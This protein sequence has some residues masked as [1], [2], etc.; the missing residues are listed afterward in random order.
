MADTAASTNKYTHAHAPAAG[1]QTCAPNSIDG[2]AARVVAGIVAAL[3]LASLWPP[4]WW[5]TIVLAIDF[6][7]RAWVGRTYSPLRWVAKRITGAL[8]V[9]VKPTYAP[10]KRFAARIGSA[11]TLLIVASHLL[12][13]G[14]LALAV[15]L[16]LVAAASLEAFASFC[17]ACWVY[18]YVFRRQTSTS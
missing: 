4:A 16:A 15:T 8:G 13:L 3:A 7:V 10:P 2:N 12:G 6:F 1:N 9:P 14:G 11:L 17:I 18:P 5:L